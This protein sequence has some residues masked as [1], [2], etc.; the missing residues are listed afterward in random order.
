MSLTGRQI[1][2]TIASMTTQ[3]IEKMLENRPEFMII[4]RD[5]KGKFTTATEVVRDEPG[6]EDRVAAY[7]IVGTVFIVGFIVGALTCWAMMS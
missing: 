5:A 4:A 6:D 2:A 1:D 3:E 7:A